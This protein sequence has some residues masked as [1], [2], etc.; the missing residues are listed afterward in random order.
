MISPEDRALLDLAA[1]AAGY[2]PLREIRRFHTA[3]GGYYIELVTSDG[4]EWNPLTDDGDSLRLA[5]YLG[6]SINTLCYDEYSEVFS[7]CYKYN[8]LALEVCSARWEHGAD[9]HA[10]TRRA[11]VLVAAEIGKAM[12]KQA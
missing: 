6:L 3:A 2:G 1:L 4:F 5:T 10:A 7:S 8:D 11:I 9:R 12:E